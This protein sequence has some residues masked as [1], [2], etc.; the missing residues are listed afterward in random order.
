MPRVTLRTVVLGL[1]IVIPAAALVSTL[2][3]SCQALTSMSTPSPGT[4][5]STQ[6]SEESQPAPNTADVEASAP[7]TDVQ[8]ARLMYDLSDGGPETAQTAVSA[9]LA[10]GDTRFVSVFVELLRANQLGLVRGVG[11]LTVAGALHALSD[12]RYGGD[13]ASWVEWYGGTELAPPP[14]FT[15]WKGE[16][17]GRI[18]PGFVEFL[19]DGA[20]SR[21]RVEEIVWGG[22]RVDGIPALD[23]AAMIPAE[24]AD[25]LDPDE[26]VFGISIDGDSRAYPLRIMDW[27]EMAND[28]VGGVPV[29]FAYCTLCG[30]GIPYDGRASDGAI[31]T[32]GSSG[33]LY[34][35][36]KLMYDR[37]TRTLWNQL[38]GEPVLGELAGSELRL[39]ILP[40]VITTWD[41]WKTQHPGTVVLNINTGYERPY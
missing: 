40:S 17:L 38:T 31:Y 6:S 12:Q 26:P 37:Q 11:P 2:L 20:P 29:S 16:L 32:F 4:L 8:A 9:I 33:F 19:Q 1:I 24:S 41:A 36:N 27:H 13:W 28:V 5:E 25:Y 30:A 22:V 3:A 35:S 23:N 21:I 10:A 7:L 18:D 39:S 14:G 34:R 15:G